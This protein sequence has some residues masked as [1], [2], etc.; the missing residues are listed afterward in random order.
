MNQENVMRFLK[1]KI[2]AGCTELALLAALLFLPVRVY[3]VGLDL[4]VS[5]TFGVTMG[6][7]GAQVEEHEFFW[8]N[9]DALLKSFSGGGLVTTDIV[10]TP[11]FAIETG[12]GFM[13]SEREFMAVDGEKYGNGI[14]SVQYNR[15]QIPFG[16]QYRYRFKDSPDEK[17]I[18]I[19]GG[20]LLS[21]FA[22]E[23]VYKDDLTTASSNYLTP[24]FSQQFFLS[25]RYVFNLG[26]GRLITGIR[27][28]IDILPLSYT[29]NGYDVDMGRS[30]PVVLELGYSFPIVINSAVEKE[31]IRKRRVDV[32]ERY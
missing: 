32:Y 26:G 6:I 9:P 17:K 18:L 11:A 14:V 12:A 19:T 10:F 1:K 30:L 22:G 5:G 4:N 25:V 20:V 13:H 29:I 2:P 23:Q 31:N 21:F 24:S 3:G 27:A 28:D 8:K 15:I 7:G 16:L